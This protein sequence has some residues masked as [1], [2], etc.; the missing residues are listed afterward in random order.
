M[1][2]SIIYTRTVLLRAFALGS[3]HSCLVFKLTLNYCIVLL[4]A[5]VHCT[6]LS[7]NWE[8]FQQAS[9]RRNK[10]LFSLLRCRSWSRY[11]ATSVKG[12]RD[13]RGVT[14]TRFSPKFNL[15]NAGRIWPLRWSYLVDECRTFLQ[16]P[17]DTGLANLCIHR[18]YIRIM[19]HFPTQL[20]IF[21][22]PIELAAI[23]ILFSIECKRE[24]SGLGCSTQDFSVR[25][26]FIV[27]V[28]QFV[29]SLDYLK[30]HK[31]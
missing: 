15:Y 9:Q 17:H 25:F 3:C 5:Y 23:L 26:L 1:Y 24:R 4:W 31:T 19:L 20:K 29:L 27:I 28:V 12:D 11:K 18:E 30:L 7:R 8:P 16:K 2:V 10:R 14:I 13:L 22:P 6:K 21:C